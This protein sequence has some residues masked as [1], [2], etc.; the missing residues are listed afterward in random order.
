MHTSV[1]LTDFNIRDNMFTRKCLRRLVDILIF[2][3]LISSIMC[4]IV[5][6]FDFVSTQ[7]IPDVDDDDDVEEEEE[8]AEANEEEEAEEEEEEEDDDWDEDEDDVEEEDG[9]AEDIVNEFDWDEPPPNNVGSSEL[10]KSSALSLAP[11]G[12]ISLELRSV[13]NCET[14][15]RRMGNLRP[16]LL[17]TDDWSNERAL[18]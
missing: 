17:F 9:G 2:W 7:P 8:G 3:E 11:S 18:L 6:A 4:W 14:S 1:K 5:F 12:D 10:V 16:S 13:I 15:A